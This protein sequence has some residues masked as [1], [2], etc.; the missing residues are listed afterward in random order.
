MLVLL[1]D[2][3]VTWG[4]SQQV[5]AEV[6]RPPATIQSGSSVHGIRAVWDVPNAALDFPLPWPPIH[7]TI[8]VSHLGHCASHG[9]VRLL[10]ENAAILFSLVKQEEIEHTRVVVEH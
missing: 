4:W 9:C 7:G 6:H 10:A 1:M 8:H 2:R 5:C 3:S